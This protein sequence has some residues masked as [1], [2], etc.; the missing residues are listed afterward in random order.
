MLNTCN[1][2]II[3]SVRS[4]LL[5]ATV[6]ASLA[7]ACVDC[8][9][10]DDDASFIGVVTADNVFVRSGPAD[11]YYP[12]G[13][14]NTGD[15]VKVTSERFGWGRIPT[16][17]PTFERKEFFGY[18]IYPKTQPG[19]FRLAGDGRTGRTLG[20]TDVLAPNLNTSFDPNDSWKPLIRLEADTTVRVLQTLESANNLV[21]KISLPDEA[22]VWVSMRFIERA[23]EQQ[24]AAWKRHFDPEQQKE[25]QA[26]AVPEAIPETLADKHQ[27]EPQ[28][29]RT[30][31]PAE[32][33]NEQTAE[34]KRE[35]EQK[36]DPP[37]LAREEQPAPTIE[38]MDEKPEPEP[39]LVPEPKP[40]PIDPEIEEQAEEPTIAERLVAA[41]LEDLENAFE[42]LRQEPI[43][44]AEVSPLR[45]MYREFAERA[46][47]EREQRFAEQRAEQLGLWEEIQQNRRR[48]AQLRSR[49][50]LTGERAEA[51]RRA[52]DDAG[53][54]I[55]IGRLA[56]STI[57][58]GRRLPQLLRLQESGTGRTVAYIQPDTDYDLTSMIGQLIGIIG[59]KEYDGGLR[60]NL[61]RAR[62]V[63]LLAPRE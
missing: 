60:L 13:R 51:A 45:L 37:V 10:A 31:A 49:A 57:Y 21:Q 6:A 35:N 63:D 22:E 38:P 36:P 32:Q 5:T 61:I 3:A 11:S 12:I 8:A 25:L 48:L 59:E 54:Y 1:C 2:N 62:R 15:L 30:D 29:E 56:V 46:E 34:A 7:F 28:T 27:V 52:V 44:T 33:P 47:E 58:D 19:R 41:S 17:G 16:T 55:A 39:V 26:E 14:V 24:Q 43:E 23:N 53:D 42:S 9:H 50:A 4:T 20:R 18:I 40:Q